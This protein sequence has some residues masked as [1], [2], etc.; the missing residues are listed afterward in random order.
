[1]ARGN[2]FYEMH[3]YDKALAEYDRALGPAG[4][5]L[6]F[7]NRGNA[8]HA[9][10][11]HDEALASFERALALKPDLHEAHNNRGNALLDLNRPAK[12]LPITT[13]RSRTSPTHSRWS[14]AA[15]RCAI[16]IGPKKRSTASIAPSRSIPNLPEAHWNKACFA[17]PSAISSAAGPAMNG[18]GA[19][20]P[21]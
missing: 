11:R 7:N 12:R 15:A 19:A 2:V 21:N 18:A 10:G 5:R 9:M 8:L 3:S 17:S 16:S 13:S 4:F 1:M 20:R 14:I 6:G